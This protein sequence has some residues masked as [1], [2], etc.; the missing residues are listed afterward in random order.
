MSPTGAIVRRALIGLAV[1][2]AAAGLAS[3][4]V[5]GDVIEQAEQRTVLLLLPTKDGLAPYCSGSF[6]TPPGTILTAS[7]CVREVK[8]PRKGQLYLP[9]GRVVIAVNLPGRVNPVP[10]LWA[11]F[12]ADVPQDD[13]ALL[14]VVELLG[15]EGKPLPQGFSV[16]HMRLG[17]VAR[18][19]KGDS[20]AVLGFP[21]VG[22][23]SITVAKGHVTGFEADASEVKRRMKHDAAVGGGA[24]GGPVVNEQGEQVAVHVASVADPQRAAAAR[25]ATLV[26]RIPQAW[27]RYLG[28]PAATPPEPGPGS[29][30]GPAPTPGP[31]PGIPPGPL[32]GAGPASAPGP[33]TAPGPRPVPGGQGVLVQGVIVDAASGKGI[34]NAG[35]FILRP[36][37][38]PEQAEEKDVLTW[39]RTDAKGFFQTTQRIR[40]GARYPAVVLAQGYQGILGTLTVPQDAPAILPIGRIP[41]DRE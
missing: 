19:R 15:A 21:G 30:P 36:G 10:K 17:D 9:Q 29:A 34:P 27:A 18:I 32:P 11:Q 33:G 38:D 23:I 4:E 7:H 22:G 41:L 3:A 25:Y 2:V 5:S 37:V 35:F 24:S 26:S 20:I 39:A 28:E 6:V 31:G 1:L 14:R 16:P 13:L 40:R 8:G 12:V